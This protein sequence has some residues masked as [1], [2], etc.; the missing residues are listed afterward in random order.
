MDKVS[1]PP[2][3]HEEQAELDRQIAA[4]NKR[5]ELKM[6]DRGIRA[7]ISRMIKGFLNANTQTQKR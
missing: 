1:W 6:E 5:T 2:I 7:W 4:W 3:S